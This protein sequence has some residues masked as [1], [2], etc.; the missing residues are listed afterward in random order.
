L[1]GFGSVDAAE[2]DLRRSDLD[3]VAVND[4]GYAA[5]IASRCRCGYD[6]GEDRRGFSDDGDT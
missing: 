5:D 6:A 4:T 2:P 3:R 1:I